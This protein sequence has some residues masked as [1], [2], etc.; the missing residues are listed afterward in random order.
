MWNGSGYPKGIRGE[1]I[2]LISR[3]ISVAEAYDRIIHTQ[4]LPIEER[5]QAAAQYLRDGTG[6]RFDPRVAETFIHMIENGMLP[7]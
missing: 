5:E 1:Q 4:R 7:R 2:P 6:T 3:I